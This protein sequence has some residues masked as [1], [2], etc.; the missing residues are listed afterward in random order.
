MSFI[1]ALDIILL[2][3]FTF[4]ISFPP[5]NY[6]TFGWAFVFM[7]PFIPYMSPVAAIAACAS[8]EI[9]YF[10]TVNN[11]NAVTVLFNIPFTM[12]FAMSSHDDPVFIFILLLMILVKAAFSAI[13]AKI[14]HHLDNPK[15]F[16]NHD[17]L[18]KIFQRQRVRIEKRNEVLGS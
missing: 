2:M 8:G 14:S 12:L 10:R 1:T 11:L 18:K 9:G 17:K 16:S 13:S 6:S 4:H 3:N 5:S 7:P 15:Y